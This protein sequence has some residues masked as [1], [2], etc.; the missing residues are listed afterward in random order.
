MSQFLASLLLKKGLL[1]TPELDEASSLLSI[2][3]G[4]LLHEILVEKEMLTDEEIVRA[5]ADELGMESVEEISQTEVDPELL[6]AVP[7]DFL[8]RHLILPLRGE[9]GGLVRVAMAD[10]LAVNTLDDVR[11]LLGQEVRPVVAAPRTILG[12]IGAFYEAQKDL[13]QKAIDE[14]HDDDT[15]YASE[16]KEGSED[17]LD[18]ARKA[19][20]VKL[21]NSLI[22][23]AVK[24]R[25]SDIHIEPY[26]RYIKLRYR[27]DGVLYDAP[28][29]PKHVQSALISRIKILSNLN[30]AE[31]RLPQDGRMNITA[32]TRK[33]DIRVSVL[34]T[35]YGER[36]VMRLLEK[37][38]TVLQLTD[39]GFLD[40]MLRR[41][42]KL[43]DR[44]YGIILVTGPTGSGKSTTLYSA[45]VTIR[46]PEKN[47][48]TV[49]DPIENQ[50]KDI[51][52]IQVKPKIG[53]GFAEGLRSI[54]RQDPDVL[55]VGEIRDHETA[56]IAVQASLTG[57]LV[58][59][60]LHTN[61]SAGAVTRLVDMGVEP[62]LIA[63][64]VIGI[65]AQRL[66]RVLCKHC[67]QPVPV[68][69]EIKAATGLPC[70]LIFQAKGCDECRGT[71]YSG[72][73]GIFELLTV[74]EAIRE[75]ISTRK[76]SG[77]IKAASIANGMITLRKDGLQKVADGWT[78]LEEVAR[79]T[80]EGDV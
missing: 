28:S 31:T 63:S 71:G 70:D 45:L 72:R 53:F 14:V 41:F 30:I 61:D 27:I 43:L 9:A 12:A 18:I 48:L 3:P 47:I 19:P 79:A 16:E 44:P 46:S 35:A 52:Q 10:P 55:M 23:E 26:E 54:L 78:T 39:L 36:V 65:L 80:Q 15:K 25:A 24:A 49:E 37:G 57:H 64:S 6:D 76:Q 32:G 33:L 58:F 75:L 7:L 20:I 42:R 22:Y 60:T 13:T 17:L 50:I 69:P 8:K 66:V 21:V 1:E 5:L 73:R 74:D 38:E 67:K 40:G 11:R 68:S 56:E 59:S 34:P 77:T 4:K 62:F 2:S 29:P 51:S